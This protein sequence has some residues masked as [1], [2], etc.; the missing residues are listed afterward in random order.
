MGSLWIG[1][2][3][4]CFVDSRSITFLHFFCLGIHSLHAISIGSV[5]LSL[6]YSTGELLPKNTSGCTHEVKIYQPISIQSVN[7]WKMCGWALGRSVIYQENHCPHCN[8]YKYVLVVWAGL[9]LGKKCNASS[10]TSNSELG[11]WFIGWYRSFLAVFSQSVPTG[12]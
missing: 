10:S 3:Y 11:S 2:T 1:I 8:S 4:S 9:I 5:A 7:D 12:K 6:R